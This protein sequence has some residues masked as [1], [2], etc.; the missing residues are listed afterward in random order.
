M[1]MNKINNGFYKFSIFFILFLALYQPI[2][3]KLRPTF[4]IPGLAVLLIIFSKLK[5]G[6]L[7]NLWATKS[8]KLIQGIIL[9]G[10]YLCI[11]ILRV[12]EDKSVLIQLV[13]IIF[14]ALLV[15]GIM[16]YR[17][18]VK[19]STNDFENIL[20]NTGLAQSFVCILMCI[21]LPLRGVNWSY[22]MKTL[23]NPF[24]RQR[25][26]S[27]DVYRFYGIAGPNQY[28]SS[29]GIVSALLFLVAVFKFIN[30]KRDVLMFVKA[31][32]L[33]IPALLDSR[34]GV[35]CAAF[36]VTVLLVFCNYKK[37]ISLS[38][39]VALWG[40]IIATILLGSMI[41]QNSFF[42]KFYEKQVSYGVH[43]NSAVDVPSEQMEN[44]KETGYSMDHWSSI[45]ID[46]ADSLATG[47]TSSKTYEW[48][49]GLLPSNWKIPSG[50]SLW[51]GT[52][53]VPDEHVQ[54]GEIIGRTDAGYARL[55]C[56]GG[57][58]LVFLSIMVLIFVERCGK[59]SNGYPLSVAVVMCF[60]LAEFK[61]NVYL[62]IPVIFLMVLIA[63]MFGDKPLN[64]KLKKHKLPVRRKTIE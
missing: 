32:L 11:T 35:L 57:I 27:I 46:A 48:Y 26:E 20:I 19:I 7:E 47:N 5:M 58:I 28:L 37:V 17:L 9:I 22:L 30:D 41:V 18:A 38:K 13:H 53:K 23:S 56:V 55:I 14:A 1:A 60:L 49:G 16:N 51:I 15:Y 42:H 3:W 64:Y 40:G 4:Y 50:Y 33:L 8:G 63:D 45:V 29:I 6:K 61:G 2:I 10:L 52:G 34:T 36:G 31:A 12:D 54:P 39:I 44:S 25:F 21:C 59:S 43:E 24:E 62:Q